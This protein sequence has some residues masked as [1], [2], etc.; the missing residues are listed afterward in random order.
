MSRK[1][2]T[3]S[4]RHVQELMRSIEAGNVRFGFDDETGVCVLG[5]MAPGDPNRIIPIAE[6]RPLIPV[7]TPAEE[8]AA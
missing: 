1:S 5:L 3:M 7:V 4:A 8:I 6:V 2:E